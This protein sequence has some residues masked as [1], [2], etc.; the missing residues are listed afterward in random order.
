MENFP[1]SIYVSIFNT[2]IMAYDWRKALNNYIEVADEV[3]ICLQYSEDNTQ[4]L[5]TNW[6]TE[7]ARNRPEKAIKI[8]NT[9]FDTKD[10]EFYGKTKNA[11]LQNSTKQFKLGLDIDETI[12]PRFLP[13]L[14]ELSKY[15]IYDKCDIIML[16]ALNLFGSEGR[17]RDIAQKFYFHHAGIKLGVNAGAR[18][19]DG[20]HDIDKSDGCDGIMSDGAIGRCL[21]LIDPNADTRYKLQHIRNNNLPYVVHWG[22]ENL[23]KKALRG[24][25]FWLSDWC[26]QSGK[27]KEEIKGVATKVED[28]GQVETIEHGLDLN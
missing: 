12:S 13:Q 18:N 1:L 11:A 23:E 24:K 2:E 8:I 25:E 6:S 5:I 7:M 9:N 28:F 20:T 22:F 21:Y 16:P 4:E 27:P 14:K 10:P 3:S 15:L 17:V 26:N 19:S